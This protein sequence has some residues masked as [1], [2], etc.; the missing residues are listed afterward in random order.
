M[1]WYL[2]VLKKY[3]VFNGRARRKEY[4]FFAL[5]NVIATII[6]AFV[7]SAL[8]TFN[9]E[10][11]IGILGMIYALAV[12][13]PAIGVAIRRLHDTGRSGWWL[14]L[15]IL[16]LIGAIVLI[17]FFVQDSAPGENEYGANPKGAAV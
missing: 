7:D 12:L 1:N 4:W 2:D 10:T 5:F 16:P 15:A 6:L 3:A 11:G 13:L 8:G 14:L 17:I 9:M